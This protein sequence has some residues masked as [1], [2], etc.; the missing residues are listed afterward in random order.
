MKKIILALAALMPALMAFS[1]SNVEEVD[2]IQSLYGMEKKVIVEN[3]V[4]PNDLQKDAF[5]QVYDEY[6]KERKLLG[7][8]RIEL[9]EEFA[10]I[11]ENMTNEQADAW[12]KKAL[13]LTARQDK[14]VMKYYAK[15]KKVTSAITALRFYQVESFLLTAI[16]LEVLDAIPFVEDEK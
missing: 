12:M 2:L 4:Q 14:N 13:D 16:R 11:Y 8:E 1:Q 6:E 3:F 9:L 7:K 10:S 15:V 5:W